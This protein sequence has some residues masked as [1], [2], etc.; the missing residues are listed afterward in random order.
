M[1][2]AVFI[3]VINRRQAKIKDKGKKEK[4]DNENFLGVLFEPIG[5]RSSIH[6]VVS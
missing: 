1:N 6:R 4:N 5:C 2:G 3:K